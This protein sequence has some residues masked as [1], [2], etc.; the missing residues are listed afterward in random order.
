DLKVVYIAPFRSLATEIEITLKKN[1]KHLGL[2]ISEFY[3][4]LEVSPSEKFLI[5]NTNIII[6]TP[7]KFDAILRCD[8]Q[9]KEEISLIIIDEGHIIGGG[10][11]RGL[12]FELF[13]QRL[14]KNFNKSRFMFISAVLPNI[15]EFAKW[16]SGNDNNFIKSEWK[17]SRL[18]IGNLIW[19]NNGSK[20]EYNYK[21]GIKFRKNKIIPFLERIDVKNVPNKG[22]RRVKIPHKINEPLGISALVFASENPTFVYA[23]KKS[24]VKSLAN[25]IIDII[26]LFYP[27]KFISNDS[28][29]KIKNKEYITQ[30]KKII[31]DEMGECDLLTYLDNGFLIHHADLPNVVKSEIENAFRN[32]AINLLIG[33]TTV[34]QG[35][36]FPVK[37][38]LV[39]GI[40]LNRNKKLDSPT[41][42]NICGRA[43][44]AGKENEG[45]VLFLLD[46]IN[47][48]YN[49]IKKLKKEYESLVE[50]RFRIESSL[51]HV[52]NKFSKNL[53]KNIK[54]SSDEVYYNLFE[55]ILKNLSDED[56][57]DYKILLE[58]F[59]A[60]LLAFS[61]ESDLDLD[62]DELLENIIKTS[63]LI[64]QNSKNIENNKIIIKSRLNYLNKRYSPDMQKR[65]YK[66][67]L[68][69]EDCEFLEDNA[70]FLINLFKQCE[71]WSIFS[72]FEKIDFLVMISSIILKL[73]QASKNISVLYNH[74]KILE[75]WLRGCDNQNIFEYFKLES[76]T[77]SIEDI[78]FFIDSCKNNLPWII[79]S[80]L[81]YLKGYNKKLPKIC[82]F[83]S[84]MFKYGV[85]DELVVI[86][87][88]FFSNDQNLSKKIATKFAHSIKNINDLI[89]WI[90][91]ISIDELV[92]SGFSE[93][94][95]IKII[96]DSFSKDINNNLLIY[97]NE[98][99]LNKEDIILLK[100]NEEGIFEIFRV[101][102]SFVGICNI[103][104]NNYKLARMIITWK[105]NEISSEIN[106]LSY[107]L[108]DYM[109]YQYN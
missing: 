33:T 49:E 3:G 21:N 86:M 70:D 28:L 11:E 65:I 18:M 98:L 88:P 100:E 37:N 53:G 105:V 45:N 102:G 104:K 78:R 74:E 80:V 57:K 109:N 26:N 52:L 69:A 12:N 40:N 60:Q 36:N 25:V 103:E 30:L 23:P 22:G 101:D 44:R 62:S 13:I 2:N 32:G 31:T 83:L 76:N 29:E 54:Y 20:I 61:E 79:N 73:R 97:S 46:N 94:E 96:P 19:D 4:R 7:E 77:N 67:G 56:F 51:K 71:N 50:S 24:E 84:E 42:W 64:I 108:V 17:P 93:D 14:K 66:S 6:L 107:S 82:G 27:Y 106:G 59:D 90:D 72:E 99:D 47:K 85:V 48:D 1:L 81:N 43:G 87:I 10:D 39:K 15:S 95:I 89:E 63:L 92:E 75:L 34:A 9:I 8:P 58:N 5:Q 35:V 41:F 91:Y 38:V 16:I 55:D 68:K